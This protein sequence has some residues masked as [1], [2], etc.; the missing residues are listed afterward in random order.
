MSTVKEHLE[1]IL[2]ETHSLAENHLESGDELLAVNEIEL[3]VAAARM[4]FE[5]YGH[6]DED[7]ESA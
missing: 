4:L 3:K 7:T 1:H 6:F 5:R 2:D